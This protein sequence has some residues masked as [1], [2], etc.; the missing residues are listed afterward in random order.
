MDF[1]I[2]RNLIVYNKINVILFDYMAV[3]SSPVNS[4]E[5][6]RVCVRVRIQARVRVRVRLRS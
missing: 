3:S 1:S 6:V 2:I 4:F 5:F